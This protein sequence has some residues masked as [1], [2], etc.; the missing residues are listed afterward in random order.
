MVLYLF[1]LF[2]WVSPAAAL[3]TVNVTVKKQAFELLSALC[4]YSPE[5]YARALDALDFYK[6]MSLTPVNK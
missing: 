5:G 4:V 2:I 3:D 1:I 6:V